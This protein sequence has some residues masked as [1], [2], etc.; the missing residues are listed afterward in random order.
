[1]LCLPFKKKDGFLRG[2]PEEIASLKT[3][4]ERGARDLG[5]EEVTLCEPL[6]VA[7]KNLLRCYAPVC[8]PGIFLDQVAGEDFVTHGSENV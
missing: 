8:L 7:C 1:M 4:T 5:E 6:H 3:E 2:R